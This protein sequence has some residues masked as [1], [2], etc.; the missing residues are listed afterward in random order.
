MKKF[1]VMAVICLMFGAV[2]ITTEAKTTTPKVPGQQLSGAVVSCIKVA[3]EKRE[4][5]VIS[6]VTNNQTNVLS[7]LNTRKTS[8]LAAWD[9]TTR[10]DV[11]SA[12][13]T[14]WS[15]YKS[16]MT[17]LRSTLSTARKGARVTYRADVKAC[18]GDTT[19]Q[20]VDTS[21]SANE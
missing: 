1:L 18:K 11:K 16:S 3:L 8:L 6:A 20:S 7:A 5:A 19:V 12:I 14:A 4:T 2:A 13:S 15:A 10:A 21:T 9:K 17:T